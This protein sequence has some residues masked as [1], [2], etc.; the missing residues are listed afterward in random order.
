ML[1]RKNANNYCPITLKEGRFYPYYEIQI[2][3]SF[4]PTLLSVWFINLVF[5]LRLSPTTFVSGKYDRDF[6]MHLISRRKKRSYV[7]R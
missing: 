7:S 3:G 5:K 1:K 2:Y 6:C 4:S